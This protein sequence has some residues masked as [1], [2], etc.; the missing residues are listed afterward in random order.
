MKGP[1]QDN[2]DL[3]SVA[4]INV[5]E[6]DRYGEL[7]FASS[8]FFVSENGGEFTVSVQRLNGFDESVSVDYSASNGSAVSGE[9]FINFR[10]TEF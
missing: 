2:L 5:Q 4:I 3:E 9:D 7:S 1:N 10:N 6:D 8:D